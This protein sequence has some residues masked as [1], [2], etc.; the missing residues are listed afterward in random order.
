MKGK[1]KLIGLVII[2]N[3]G[4]ILG[5]V[6]IGVTL[7]NAIKIEEPVITVAD[8]SVI[9]EPTLPSEVF[10]DVPLI[11]QF[12]EPA[13]Y[14]GCEVTSLAMVMNYSGYAINKNQ[15]AEGINK[16]PFVDDEGY[17]GN[18]NIGF[19]GDIEGNDPGLGVYNKPIEEL[20]IKYINKDKVINITGSSFQKV[21]EAIAQGFPVW[22]IT[23]IDFMPANDFEV[24]NTREGE[25]GI[26]YS[27][28]SVVLTGYDEAYV[29]LNDPY[30]EK[31]YKTDKEAFIQAWQQL[32]SQGIY[33]E[34]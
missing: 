12:E 17:Y 2:V 34:R 7:F 29:Y 24:W 6:L 21:E 14:N 28:H 3:L 15:L 27:M 18:L 11:Y 19:V 25:M 5:L 10:L 26:T 32:D 23:T 13:L 4:V 31:D 33:I 8:A 1:G 22:T 9:E 30:G 16:V 20:L